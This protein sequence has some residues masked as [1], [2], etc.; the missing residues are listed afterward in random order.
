MLKLI[1]AGIGAFAV[2][3]GWNPVSYLGTGY[4]KTLQRGLSGAALCVATVLTTVMVS[5]I[6]A[7]RRVDRPTRAG[8]HYCERLRLEVN[9]IMKLWQATIALPPR[10]RR[11]Y[12]DGLGH[13][14]GHLIRAYLVKDLDPQQLGISRGNLDRIEQMLD[15]ILAVCSK[16]SKHV[17]AE[18]GGEA[19]DDVMYEMQSQLQD[20]TRLIERLLRG[21]E[22]RVTDNTGGRTGRR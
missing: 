14:V 15:N 18:G 9:R 22:P 1:L 4:P 10:Q 17:H 12:Q 19:T 7:R 5:T 2:G 16:I 3:V 20:M 6:L 21:Q 11:Q 13:N 8:V